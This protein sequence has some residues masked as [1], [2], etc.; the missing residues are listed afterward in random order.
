LRYVANGYKSAR[1]M[2]ETRART[3]FLMRA[4]EA[5]PERLI[6]EMRQV[7][8]ETVARQDAE[9]LLAVNA[10]RVTSRRPTMGGGHSKT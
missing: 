3:H 2:P 9:R 4:G 7:A 10:R 1:A 6:A 8:R 5:I